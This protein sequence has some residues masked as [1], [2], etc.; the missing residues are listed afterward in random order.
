MKKIKW[1]SQRQ[2][3][4]PVLWASVIALLL[5]AAAYPNLG[6]LHSSQNQTP[7]PPVEAKN[8][9]QVTDI[10]TAKGVFN[11]PQPTPTPRIGP[12]TPIITAEGVF[13]PDLADVKRKPLIDAI[14][15]LKATAHCRPPRITFTVEVPFSIRDPSFA[16]QLARARKEALEQ[17][18]PSLGLEPDQYKSDVKIE[19]VPG[20]LPDKGW[21]ELNLAEFNEVD[22]DPPQIKLTSKPTAGTCVQAGDQ[23]EVTIRASERYEDGHKSWPSGVQ[24]I[25]LKANGVGVEP[26]GFWRAPDPCERKTLTVTYKVPSPAPSAVHLE[27]IVDDAANP[28]HEN[29]KSL[30][31]PTGT[32]CKNVMPANCKRK[33]YARLGVSD[34]GPL[35]GAFDSKSP[36]Y[37]MISCNFR[38]SICAPCEGCWFTKTKVVKNAVGACSS[39]FTEAEASLPK[40]AYCCDCFPK[41]SETKPKPKP[42]R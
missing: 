29:S 11:T 4:R 16:Q 22:R 6:A 40:E 37:G 3:S 28:T 7:A 30:D 2:I 26:S 23:I 10:I 5:G 1:F 13:D 17:E 19:M 9:P 15:Q 31:F 39:F 35:L 12:V 8:E 41:C 33:G 42:R 38:W 14:N 25:Q 18:L 32:P 24:M 20:S 21:V 36:N 27:A 34:A